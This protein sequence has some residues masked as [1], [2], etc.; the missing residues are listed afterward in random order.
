M[1]KERRIKLWVIVGSILLF[2]LWWVQRGLGDLL[3]G[4]PFVFHSDYGTSWVIWLI[5]VILN[6]LICRTSSCIKFIHIW[7]YTGCM[8]MKRNWCRSLMYPVDEWLQYIVELLFSNFISGPCLIKLL[9]SV[10]TTSTNRTTNHWICIL[11]CSIHFSFVSPINMYE[12]TF[13]T[14]IIDFFLIG[15]G[16]RYILYCL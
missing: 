5:K 1:C 13:V 11:M 9:S 16:R 7:V 14:G 4:Y 10:L 6:I 8:W 2:N 15:C 3:N 12:W